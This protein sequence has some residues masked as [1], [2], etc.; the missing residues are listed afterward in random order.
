MWLPEEDQATAEQRK[1]SVHMK[2]NVYVY[3]E[4][5]GFEESLDRK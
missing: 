2:T 3:R 1:S 4:A 5:A